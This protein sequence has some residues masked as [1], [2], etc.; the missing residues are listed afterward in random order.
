[1]LTGGDLISAERKFKGFFKFVNFAKLIF[2]CN[3]IPA[4]K[5]DT[6][7]FFRRWVIIDFPNKFEGE[8]ANPNILEEMATPEELSGFLNWALEGLRRLLKNKGFSYS[9]TTNEIREKYI[10]GSNPVL[11]FVEKCI[12]VDSESYIEKDEL[13]R[14]FCNFCREIGLPIKDMSVFA[15]ELL[16]HVNVPA[17]RVTKDD[18]RKNVWRGIKLR[19]EGKK[20]LYPD[21]T[22]EGGGVRDGKDILYFNS[23]NEYIFS[24]KIRKNPDTPDNPDTNDNLAGFKTMKNDVDENFDEEK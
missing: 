10:M 12:E 2:S 21:K 4:T 19:E 18:K 23:K 15:R 7:A 24:N 17:G 3:K 13:Y 5:D 22:E 16:Q 14:A 20:Y 11:A 8:K 1:M 6:D 9:F